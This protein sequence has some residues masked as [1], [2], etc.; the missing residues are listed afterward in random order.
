MN[1]GYSYWGFLAD[2]KMNDKLEQLSTP[3]G[4][5]FYSW[6]II[7]E[8]QSRGHNVTSIMPD[9]DQFAVNHLHKDAFSSWITD[10]RYNAYIKMNHINY[11]KALNHVTFVD[12]KYL[13]DF[14]GLNEYDYIIHEW[15]MPIKG[16]NTLDAKNNNDWQPDLFLQDCLLK[17]CQLYNIKLFIFDLDYKLNVSDIINYDNIDIIELGTKWSNSKVYI[18]FGFDHINEFPI[19][20]KENRKYDLIY[21][22]NRYER[23]WCIDKYISEDANCIIHGNWQEGGRDSVNRWPNLTF[24]K[25]L[26]TSEMHGAYS[27]AL[28]TILLAKKEYCNYHFMTARLIE[29]IFYG[30]VPFFIEEYGKETIKEYAGEYADFLTVRNKNDVLEK[31]D[32]LKIR[33]DY[34]KIIDYLRS[35]LSKMDAAYFIN[36]LEDRL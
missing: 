19:I 30:T 16:R 8:L 11:P 27:N 5:A 1:I 33:G 34:E 23:D 36:A 18:P 29:S 17:Y 4:N 10:D 7:R 24:G 2:I 21:I 35:Y 6:S 12:I 22:G 32:T 28:C 31:I 14:Y 13:W 25:R 26:Q 15:R 9:R 3:D 20:S